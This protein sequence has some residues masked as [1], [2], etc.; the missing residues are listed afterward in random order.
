MT[1]TAPHFNPVRAQERAAE[2]FRM[3]MVR[4]ASYAR[5]FRTGMPHC[6]L[7]PMQTLTHDGVVYA[8][9]RM[10]GGGFDTLHP[11]A[12][13]EVTIVSHASGQ[14][15]TFGQIIRKERRNKKTGEVTVC[16]NTPVGNFSEWDEV[17][18][19]LVAEAARRLH[20][21]GSVAA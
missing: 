3:Q 1:H 14:A 5:L 15:T 21:M 20:H 13:H 17:A 18:A 12:K 8:I 9:E 19:A 6:P 4:A 2:L 11:M 7:Y 10:E 16:Y